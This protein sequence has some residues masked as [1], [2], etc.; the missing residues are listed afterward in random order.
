MNNDVTITANGVTVGG[1]Q[2]VRISRSVERMAADFDLSMT[3]RF[4]G[5]VTD[6]TL[7]P[8][9]SC[10]IRI[11]D[12]LVLSGFVDRLS[13]GLDA[14][15]HSLRV[16]G[17]SRTA[18]LVD[19]SAYWQ[20]MTLAA[21]NI[22]DLAQKL[23]GLYGVDVVCN[24]AVGLL[25]TAPLVV[26]NRG[27][28]VAD[29]LERWGR[30][31]GVM[32][33][34]D[35]QGR[36][37]ITRTNRSGRRADGGVAAGGFREGINVEAASVEF[38]ADERFRDYEWFETPVDFLRGIGSSSPRY[39]LS[40]DGIE[41]GRLKQAIAENMQP[42]EEILQQRARWEVNRR[43]ARSAQVRVITDSWRDA[44]GALWAVNTTAALELPTLKVT[45]VEWLVG[46]VTMTRDE[47][48]THADLLLMDAD[49]FAPEPMGEPAA[50][51]DGAIGGAILGR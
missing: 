15:T 38:S 46:E 22:R 45:G 8:Q 29:L 25:P 9:S 26:I 42:Y 43:R 24:V 18:D 14:R 19:C 36:L 40:D 5:A 47:S 3:E 51:R 17:R 10:E 31:S 39:A 13:I 32:L 44:A 28:S 20:N 30:F 16:T 34:D 1:W 11:G 12:D 41:R 2:S 7:P 37:V 23:A 50:L 49:G 6:V 35:E 21:T 48:G 27:E 33:F 4:P